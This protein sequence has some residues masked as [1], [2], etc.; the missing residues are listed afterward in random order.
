VVFLLREPDESGVV[1]P[2]AEGAVRDYA[3]M[4]D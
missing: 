3:R 4:F 2:A 1:N